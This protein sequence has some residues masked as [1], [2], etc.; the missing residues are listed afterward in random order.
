LAP[1]GTRPRQVVW[2]RILLGGFGAAP[3][4]NAEAELVICL[5]LM[6]VVYKALVIP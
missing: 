5:L 4:D 2:K 1:G 6:C 3:G